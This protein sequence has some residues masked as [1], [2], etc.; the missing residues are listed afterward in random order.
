M[1]P[2]LPSGSSGVTLGRVP[3]SVDAK[4]GQHFWRCASG[5][6]RVCDHLRAGIRR[7]FKNCPKRKR[8]KQTGNFPLGICCLFSFSPSQLAR[9]L[10]ISYFFLRASSPLQMLRFQHL[11]ET[12]PRLSGLGE[13]NARTRKNK[14]P[15][16]REPT[17]LEMISLKPLGCF[18][19]KA[20]T[21]PRVL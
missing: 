5:A 16:S 7:E 21:V 12:S 18:V 15:E 9:R 11:M 3:G 6:K 10:S 1:Q 8:N 19:R 2:E 13:Q 14:M 17:F 20:G 4:E